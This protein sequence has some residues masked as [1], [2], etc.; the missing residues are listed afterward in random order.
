MLLSIIIPCFNEEQ[1]VLTIL[2]KVLE[3]KLFGE[4]QKEIIV[5]NDGSTDQTEPKIKEFMKHHNEIRLVT[6]QN[7]TGKGFAIRKGLEKASGDILLIQDAD[8]EYDPKDYNKLIIPI[9]DRKAKVVYGSRFLSNPKYH[10]YASTWYG[11]RLLTFMANILYD[12]NITDES[13]CYKVF[14]REVLDKIKLECKRFEF[15]PEITAKVKKAGFDILEVP[16]RY[17]P[18]KYSQGKKIRFKDGLEAVWTLI[19]YKM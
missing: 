13:T 15:C 11:T 9:I 10:L 12:A 4:L 8:L 14:H 1:T 6:Y 16:I 2:K 19:K 3:V 18:R 17:T 7:N 5:V